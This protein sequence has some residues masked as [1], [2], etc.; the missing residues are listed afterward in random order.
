MR[1]QPIFIFPRLL[2]GSYLS[3]LTP[4]ADLIPD[5]PAIN[6]SLISVGSLRSGLQSSLYSHL[7]FSVT[8]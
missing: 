5:D 7:Q 6:L 2:L 8:A 1:R 3:S 4:K